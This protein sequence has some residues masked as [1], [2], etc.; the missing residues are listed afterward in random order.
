MLD[1]LLKQFSEALAT[2]AMRVA[3]AMHQLEL[4]TLIHPQNDR[5]FSGIGNVICLVCDQGTNKTNP[6]H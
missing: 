4:K 6:S 2:G 3:A 5:I 1:V